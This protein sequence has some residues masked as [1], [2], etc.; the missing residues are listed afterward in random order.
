MCSETYCIFSTKHIFIWFDNMKYSYCF[1]K[2]IYVFTRLLA[3]I[4]RV[5]PHFSFIKR[6]IEI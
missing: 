3:I 4:R 2:R 6:L 1:L 5:D